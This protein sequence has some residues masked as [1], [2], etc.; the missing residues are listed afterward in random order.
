MCLHSCAR[1]TR[2]S[3]LILAT[4]YLNRAKTLILLVTVLD[5]IAQLVDRLIVIAVSNSVAHSQSTIVDIYSRCCSVM[6]LLLQLLERL[7]LAIQAIDGACRVFMMGCARATPTNSTLRAA[8]SL[9]R[10][11]LISARSRI[12]TTMV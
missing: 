7:L 1:S 4:A 10:L 3:N 8:I 12:V 5:E 9:E 6:V 11:I 2:A